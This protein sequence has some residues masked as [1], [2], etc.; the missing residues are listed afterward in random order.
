MSL[1][2]LKPGSIKKK[3][4]LTSTALVVVPILCI[5]LILNYSLGKK[6]EAD[7]LA[8]AAGE[9]K[10]VDNVISVLLDN[11]MTNMD[12]MA[13]HPAMQRLDSSL[14]NYVARTTDTDLKTL[15]R[16]PLETEIYNHFRMI[17][18]ANPNL[19]ELYMGTK[20]G[21]FVTD[22]QSK[23]KA[24][25]DPRKRP[26]YQDAVAQKGKASIAKAY[27]STT[28]E[29]VTAVVKSFH[30]ADGEVNYVL[31]I[32]ISLKRLTEILNAIKI[33]ETGYLILVEG[34]GTVLTHPTR[35]ELLTKNISS[36][37]IPELTEAVKNNAA[38][39]IYKVDGVEKVGRVMAASRGGWK[40]VSVIDRS[41]IQA[42]ARYLMG[43]VVLVGL[44][45]TVLAV[46]TAYAMANRI[47]S[48]ISRINVIMQEIARG[49]GDLTRRIDIEGNDEIAETARHFN[50]FLESLRGMFADIRREAVRLTEGVH[51]VNSVLGKL[52]DDFRELADQSSSNAATIEEITVSISHIAGNAG[53]ADSLVKQTSELSVESAHTIA[54]VAGKAGQSAHE[55]ENLSALL[56]QLSQRSQEISGIT[57]VIKEIADQTNLLALNAAIE[58]AR[59]GEQGRGF[60]VVADE[61]RK[62]AER[63]GEATLQ[64]T[65]M[66]EGMRN[67]TASAVSNMKQTLVSAQGGVA[68]A[69]AA[70]SKIDGIRNNMDDVRSKMEEIAH[71]THEEQTAT[72]LMARSAEGITN[73]MQ[74]SEDELEKATATLQELDRVAQGLQ[75]K[76]SSFR[77]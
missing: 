17:G 22:D 59:A 55:V 35:K 39:F 75:D 4:F 8:R 46:V 77:T 23:V 7:F 49:G 31:G 68:F 60:A 43:I 32:D 73:R 30:G 57:Q 53:E 38:S 12:L 58:A 52:S 67:E 42:S 69:E 1:D 21:G 13:A 65:S 40:L 16:G 9:M 54:E 27:L 62:L 36:V 48:G 11:A 66:T 15:T 72:T 50:T 64:I 41:E 51:S 33:G 74:R 10:Q 34:D 25:Y 2:L 5:I 3:L 61:V 70:A 37:N 19:L 24:G 71:S 26:W 56:E 18:K 47:T 44:V 6:S 29:N 76:F 63:T 28:G 20:Q 45:F 14:N